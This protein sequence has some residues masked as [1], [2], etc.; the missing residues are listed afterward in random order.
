MNILR[1]SNTIR[2]WSLVMITLFKQFFGGN[3]RMKGE[4]IKGG[5]LFIF[6]INARPNDSALFIR[7]K[8]KITSLESPQVT[9]IS[10]PPGRHDNI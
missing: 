9:T 2:D 4:N 8:F 3:K 10:L 7:L 6:S 1:R 5:M